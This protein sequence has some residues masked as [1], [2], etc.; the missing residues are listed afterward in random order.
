MAKPTLSIEDRLA[1]IERELKRLKSS[2]HGNG[3]QPLAKLIAHEDN[4]YP[5]STLIEQ[6]KAAIDDPLSS[7]LENGVHFVNTSGRYYVKPV[8]YLRAMGVQVND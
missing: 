3:W 1:A 2:A 8:P 6:M 5:R 7:P 4:P